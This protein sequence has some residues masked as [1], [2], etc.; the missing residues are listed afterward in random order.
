M[1]SIRSTDCR[2]NFHW[3]IQNDIESGS[4]QCK[5][6][7]FYMPPLFLQE[8]KWRNT[9]RLFVQPLSTREEVKKYLET[10]CP[11]S[12]I[13]ENKVVTSNHYC[14]YILLKVPGA[15]TQNFFLSFIPYPLPCLQNIYSWGGGQKHISMTHVLK[16]SNSN[17][18]VCGLEGKILRL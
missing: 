7:D 15:E 2:N 17:S 10:V 6:K 13:L 4:S 18:L 8:R 14:T 3:L 16:K 5:W 9:W 12:N 1:L 11:T